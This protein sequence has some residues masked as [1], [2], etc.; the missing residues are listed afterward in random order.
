MA[1]ARSGHRRKGRAKV[2]V[3]G[4]AWFPM[5]TTVL[6]SAAFQTLSDAG[7]ALLWEIARQYHG[8]DNGRMLLSRAYLQPRGWLSNDRIQKA[9]DELL[10]AGLIFQTVLGQR[11]NKAGWYAATWWAL[12]KLDG[13]DPGTE[14][15]FERA[16]YKH[17]RAKPKRAAPTFSKTKKNAVL[18][19]ATG[20]ESASIAPVRGTE[21]AP[22][23]PAPGTISAAF[24]HSPVPVAGHPLDMPSVL[25]VGIGVQGIGIQSARPESASGAD[26]LQTRNIC[27]YSTSELMEM[28]SARPRP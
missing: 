2:D 25:D 27:D 20:T 10:A 3:D 23:V 26:G 13:Y 22:P 1:N 19:P 21:T 9:K 11:P 7:K 5:P 14:A 12:D 15:A 24:A 6:D 28:L 4:G 8:N 16:A 17:A 18:T